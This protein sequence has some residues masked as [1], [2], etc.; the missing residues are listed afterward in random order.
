MKKNKLLAGD[1]ILFPPYK[2][3]FIAEA[4]AYLTDGEVNHAALCYY[5]KYIIIQSV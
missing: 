1:V 5:P 2:D 4:I 3:D